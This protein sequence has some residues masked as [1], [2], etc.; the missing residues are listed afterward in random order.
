MADVLRGLHRLFPLTATGFVALAVAVPALWI[1]GIG[2]VDHVLVVAGAAALLLLLGALVITFVGALHARRALASAEPRT[3][4]LVAGTPGPTGVTYATPLWLPLLDVRWTVAHP[5]VEVRLVPRGRTLHEQW[6]A[7]RRGRPDRVVR[8]VRVGDAFGLC[9]IDL[10][11]EAP[12]DALVLPAEGALRR[13]E[14]VQGLAAGDQIAHPEGSPVGDL[15]DMRQYGA[16]DPIRYVLWKVF[17]KSRTLMVR[18][19]E[20]A[21]APVTRTAAYLVAG[22]HDQAAAGT[23]R[24]AVECGALGAEWVFGCDGTSTVIRDRKDLLPLLLASAEHPL[25]QGGTGL[26]AFLESAEDPRR[27]VVF[28]PA[29]GGPWVDRVLGLARSREVELVLCAD[30]IVPARPR[31]DVRTLVLRPEAAG[32]PGEVVV[33]KGELGR[34]VTRVAGVRDVRVVDR[35]AGVVFA[36][37][38]IAA[39]ARGAA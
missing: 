20:R 19:P 31:L 35:Q 22:R 6:T 15:Q 3:V 13:V 14:V 32:R 27:I 7:K 25:D 9:A 36:G 2:H 5:D 21:L 23:A 37:A 26:P 17:A 30:R 4:R 33:D 39:L 16:G 24:T 18:T 10:R 11:L 34:L 38:H 1:V 29:V 8:T 12:L 28:A